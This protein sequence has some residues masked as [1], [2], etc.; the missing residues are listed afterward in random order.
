MNKCCL[1]DVMQSN[2]HEKDVKVCEKGSKTIEQDK[3]A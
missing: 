2:L 3:D 1:L